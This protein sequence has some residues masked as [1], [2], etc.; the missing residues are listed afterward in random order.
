M[1]PNFD[2]S[3]HGESG[4]LLYEDR[5]RLMAHEEDLLLLDTKKFI[6]Q[7]FALACVTGIKA[8]DKK[9]MKLR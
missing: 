9:N 7:A 4:F 8:R 3:A 6:G 2:I 5:A 1:D